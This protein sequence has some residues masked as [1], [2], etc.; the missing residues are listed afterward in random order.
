VST[1]HI[2]VRYFVILETRSLEAV[3][4]TGNDNQTK[5]KTAKMNSPIYTRVTTS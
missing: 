1:E 3:T 4:Y 5:Q 2:I